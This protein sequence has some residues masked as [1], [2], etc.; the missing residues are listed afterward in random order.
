M[1]Y[2]R[3]DGVDIY[4]EGAGPPDGEAVVFLE[5]LSY[6]TWMW[7]WQRERLPEGYRTVVVDNRGTGDSGTPEGPYTVAAMAGDVE[8]VLADAGL[9]EVHV[10]GAS[11]GGMVAQEFA[12]SYGRATSLALLCTT[13][14]GDDAVPIPEETVDRMLNVPEEYGPAERIRYRMKPAFSEAFWAENTDIVDRIVEWRLETDPT[15]A[16]YEW[17]SAA[18][19]TFDASDR[20]AEIDV[21][22]LV[23]HGTADRVLPVENAHLLA[24]GVPGADLVTVEGGSHLFFIEDADAVTD[25]LREFLDDV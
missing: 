10:V 21:P 8:A 22:T 1:P 19:K 6:G 16:A 12:L 24:E 20:L 14:G 25:H 11:L 4:Y 7:D 23:M 15:E 2:A 13:P 5:G 9:D 18:A 3:N 17:Q